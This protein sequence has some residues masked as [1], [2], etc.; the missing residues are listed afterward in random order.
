MKKRTLLIIGLLAVA[1]YAVA[2][3]AKPAKKSPRVT[4]SKATTRVTGPL[5]KKGYV[6]YAQVINQ[7]LSVGVTAENNANVLLW[8]AMGPA[9]EQTELGPRILEAMNTEMLPE[10][11]DYF[12]DLGTFCKQ[13]LNIK[14]TSPR[15]DKIFEQQGDGMFHPWSDQKH[16]ELSAW[17]KHNEKPLAVVEEATMRPRYFSPLII[18]PDSEVD[19]VEASLVAALL[20]SV[21]L[22]RS[23][24]RA[25][26]C[27][28]MLHLKHGRH[29][30]AWDDILTCHR[31]GRLV[32]K[33]PTLVESLVGIAICGI[34]SEATVTYIEH[35]Q[36]DAKVSTQH[37][38][39]LAEMPP[40]PKM[41]DRIDLCERFIFLDLVQR[42]AASEGNK[43]ELLSKLSGS[44]G[45]DDPLYW[46]AIKSA[47]NGLTDWDLVMKEGN[48]AYD[49]IVKG[50][51]LEDPV[52]R[53]AAL[54]AFELN[55]EK[56]NK[57]LRNPLKMLAR[58]GSAKSAADG[59][60]SV[61]GDYIICLMMPALS[62]CQNAEIR[63]LQTNDNLTV[64]LAL[65]SYHSEH[66][67]YPATLASLVPKHL[68]QLPSDRFNG[69]PLIY[70]PNEQGYIFYSVGQNKKDEQGRFYDDEPRGDDLRIQMPRKKKSL[71]D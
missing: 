24:A 54:D 66:G 19:D 9:P 21:Q 60:G 18:K 70:R 8:K 22:T 68:K 15:W 48:T 53:K 6:D 25:L 51:R 56:R 57:Q 30:Q 2:N 41:V 61:M 11:G 43:F 45:S 69:K 7:R 16:S 29:E 65:S 46:K 62:S 1:T 44:S 58:I 64:A 28:A 12:L 36:P 52:A 32:A 14:I 33:G 55:I 71:E 17:L 37:A 38:R 59:L 34:A 3:W 35:A 49:Q 40:L 63:A 50:M 4:V 47:A 31:L 67:K 23:F 5:T 26:S 39:E 42:L 27:R 10:K 13:E 20:P